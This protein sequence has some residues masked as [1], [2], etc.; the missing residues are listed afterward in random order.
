[1]VST[2]TQDRVDRNTEGS[3]DRGT[4]SCCEPELHVLDDLQ[5]YTKKYIQQRPEAAAL[6]CL[7]IG[8]VL[9]WKLKPW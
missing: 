2:T 1:M 5:C 6:F 8:F 9:G 7:G 3:V 4:Q